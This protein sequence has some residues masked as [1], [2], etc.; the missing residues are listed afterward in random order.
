MGICSVDASRGDREGPEKGRSA[1]FARLRAELRRGP[2]GGLSE[3]GVFGVGPELE[4]W[5]VSQVGAVAHRYGYIALE[6]FASGAFEGRAFKR[7]LEC[8][9]VELGQR[10]EGGID[11]FGTGF[12][13]LPGC[14]GG[15]AVPGADVLADVT[16]K[17]LSADE[18]AEI[19]G[20]RAFFLD[21]EV[22]DAAGGVHLV[23][24]DEGVSGAGVDAAGAGAAAIL[25][26]EGEAVG[27]GQWDG[28]GDDTE[29]EPGAV[30]LGEDAGVLAD[31][32]DAGAR[33]EIAF[34][35]R[36]GVDITAGLAGGVLLEGGFESAE[37]GEQVV[38]VV[39]GEEGACRFLAAQSIAGDPAG[40]QGGGV[41]GAGYGGVV[42]E[43]ADQD[44]ARPGEGDLDG[45]AEE[46]ASVVTALE[47]VHLS[48]S[49]GVDPGG[50]TGVVFAGGGGDAGEV[51]AGVA[52][53]LIYRGA[54]FRGPC[55]GLGH[56]R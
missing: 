3:N 50:K 33:G 48:G 52:G 29:E 49:T 53:E 41:D 35:E 9:V 12:N 14:Y 34:E 25:R 24:S 1:A 28:G 27:L 31:P 20:N 47:V 39:G 11:Q 8:Y 55:G 43:G 54:K 26:R 32:A 44:G 15:F 13:C 40:V 36:A 42:V 5:E 51:E 56:V 2:L 21:G 4:L 10:F 7:L 6:A 17:D 30:S 45:A 37:A 19:F 38:V 16:A 18:G 22:G 46:G 23:R